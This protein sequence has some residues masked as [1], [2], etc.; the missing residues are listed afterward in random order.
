MSGNC[1]LFKNFAEPSL[2]QYVRLAMN[3][4][5]EQFGVNETVDYNERYVA[6]VLIYPRKDVLERREFGPT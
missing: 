1:I 4:S 2:V 5:P 3:V 6:N